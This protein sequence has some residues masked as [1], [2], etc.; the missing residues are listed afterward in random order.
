MKIELSAEITS[1]ETF[2]TNVIRRE[3]LAEIIGEILAGDILA[4]I[5]NAVLHVL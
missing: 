5:S 1:R 4:S 3:D 2:S